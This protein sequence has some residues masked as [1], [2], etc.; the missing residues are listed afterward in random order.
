MELAQ[1]MP[2]ASEVGKFAGTEWLREFGCESGNAGQVPDE[3][4]PLAI[5]IG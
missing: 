5:A 3:V 1:V 4:V 2:E